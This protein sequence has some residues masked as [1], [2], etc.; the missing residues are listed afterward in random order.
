MRYFARKRRITG[1]KLLALLSFAFRRTSTC[2][3]LL[4]R[5]NKCWLARYE[6]IGTRDAE[7]R[8]RI[9]NFHQITSYVFTENARR[10]RARRQRG[11]LPEQGKYLQKLRHIY[12]ILN[13]F[14]PPFDTFSTLPPPLFH[15]YL[16]AGASRRKSLKY[17]ACD[18]AVR[19]VARIVYW[20]EIRRW[21]S[22]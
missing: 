1:Q 2:E 20:N 19:T 5:A 15:F 13:L 22:R 8:V 11:W 14:F 12:I 10:F 17:P 18:L 6:V 16:T 4:E 21:K 3:Y 9:R 7:Q